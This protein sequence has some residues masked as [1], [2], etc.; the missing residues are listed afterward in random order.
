MVGVLSIQIEA[1][2]KNKRANLDKI[3]KYIEEYQLN[4]CKKLD[5]VVL[6]EFFLSGI[7]PE[8]ADDAEPI[9][10]SEAIKFLSKLALKYNTN[11]V[12]GATIIK[13]TDDKL[14]NMSFVLNRQGKIVAQ[15]KKIHLFKYFGGTENVR[16]TEGSEAVV[17]ELD[18]AKVGLAICFDI[19]Y[20]L[21]F[22]KLIKMGAEI[23]V[24]PTAWGCFAENKLE[25]LDTTNVLKSLNIARAAENLVYFVSANLVGQSGPLYLVGNSMVVSPLGEVLQ[26]AGSAQGAIWTKIDLDVVRKLKT[27]YPVAEID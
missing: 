3:K 25:V 2:T 24:L 5:L 20:P 4:V 11:I 8:Y 15:Y 18:F 12:T 6:P 19:R 23:I 22:K 7:Y 14:Y 16:I 27:T 17:V 1:V 21:H 26:N 10:D 13:D 9:E